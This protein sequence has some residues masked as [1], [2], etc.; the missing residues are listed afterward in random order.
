MDA[1]ILVL[2]SSGKRNDFIF[3]LLATLATDGFSVRLAAGANSLL[4]A[5]F[6]EARWPWR[7]WRGLWPGRSA[8]WVLALPYFWLVNFFVLAWYKYARQTTGIIALNWPEKVAASAPAKLLGL[9]LIWLELPNTDYQALAKPWRWFF[10]KDSLKA[11]IICFSLTTKLALINLGLPEDNIKLIWPG[12]D[13]AEVQQQAD[14]FQGLAKQNYPQAAGNF[15]TV[16]TVVDLAEPQ[17]IENL[18]RVLN[19]CLTVTPNLRLIVIGDGPARAQVDWLAKKLGLE[20]RVW[21]VG[22]QAD[23][24]KWCANFNLFI[25]ANARPDL[26]D[27]IVALSAMA[28]AV[29]VIAPQDMSLDDCFLGGQAGILLSLDSQEELGAQIIKLQQN[30]V[31]RKALGVSARRVVKDF[32]SWQRAAQEFKNAIGI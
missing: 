10:Q 27:F 1:N 20:S 21:L 12:V 15:F 11:G 25:V 31:W 22:G 17:K 24:K 3:R 18:I 28:N 23:L 19:N 30:V 2:D 7:R 26:D 4:I 13:L 32:F 29:P 14:I 9:R 16:G 8:L 5:K 6:K